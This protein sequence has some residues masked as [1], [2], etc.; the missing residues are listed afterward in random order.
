MPFD[1][2]ISEIQ[3]ANTE[4]INKYKMNLKVLDN[5]VN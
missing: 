3:S 5:L 1:I 2:R 4:L